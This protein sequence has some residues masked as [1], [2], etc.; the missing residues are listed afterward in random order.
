M[1]SKRRSIWSRLFKLF[2]SSPVSSHPAPSSFTTADIPRKEK[3][4]MLADRP[5]KTKEELEEIKEFHFHIYW[6]T[7][8]IKAKE[9]ALALREEV[10]R[11]NKSGFFVAVPLSHVNEV[12]RGPHP[13]GSYEIWCPKEHFSRCYQWLIVNRPEEVSI[14]IHPLS[15]QEILDH[16][17]RAAFVGPSAPL[18]LDALSDDLD[19][20]PLQ[21]PELGLGY[22]ARE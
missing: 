8:S 6:L 17:Y 1:P 18:F 22:S 21:Y 3:L 5:N 10:F 9:A 13:M 7:S 15:R 20:P 19:T 2:G 11:L 12:P 4:A 14:F 16:S